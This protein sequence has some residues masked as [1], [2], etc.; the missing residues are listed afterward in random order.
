MRDGEELLPGDG[1]AR[2][3]DDVLSDVA[4]QEQ[5]R[6]VI[7]GRDVFTSLVNDIPWQS[8]TIK[9]FGKEHREPR[10]TAWFGDEGATYTYSGIRLSPLAWTD[11]LQILR[12]VC[13]TRSGAS[14]NSVLLNLYLIGHENMGGHADD[15]SELGREP[16]IASLSLGDTRRFRFK[17]RQNKTIVE[18]ELPHGSLLVMSGLTQQCW[19]HEV[20]RQTRVTEPRINLTFRNIVL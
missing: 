5:L 17:H 20:P 18:C 10:M 6:R 12:E 16:I 7:G 19:V 15:E 4:V 1:S 2:M 11:T 9:M 3:Y 8:R 13:A 14:F